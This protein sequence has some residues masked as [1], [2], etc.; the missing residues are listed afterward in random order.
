[1][2]KYYMNRVV[3]EFNTDKENEKE[4]YDK[5]KKFSHPAAIVKD[6]ITGVLPVEILTGGTLPQNKDIVKETEEDDDDD[7]FVDID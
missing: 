7:M 1:M 3:L 4:I 2:G 5:L 6:I